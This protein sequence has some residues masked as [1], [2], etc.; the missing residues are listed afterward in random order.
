MSLWT[1]IE[2]APATAA[3]FSWRKRFGGDLASVKPWFLKEVGGRAQTVP[4]PWTCGCVHRVLPDNRATCDCGDCEDIE[5][6]EDD[7]ALW[8]PNW[9]GLGKAVAKALECRP[10]DCNEVHDGVFEIGAF[11]PAAVPVFLI[12]ARD[13]E[14]FRV[15]VSELVA[16]QRKAFGLLA[17]T[18][19]HYD[20][21]CREL[22]EGCGAVFK[23]LETNIEIT[24]QGALQ[25][26]TG[27]VAGELLKGLLAKDGEAMPEDTA[28][29]VFAII[30]KM[31]SDKVT[32]PP[33]VVAVFRMVCIEGVSTDKAGP[34]L[35]CSKGTVMNRVEAIKAAT[36]MTLAQLRRMSGHF[37]RMEE[38]LTDSRAKNIYRRGQTGLLED[39]EDGEY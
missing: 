36:G 16:R 25:A 33:S 19:R 31:E 30:Q 24:A 13:G 28:R 1:K 4:C 39:D 37:E 9:V 23:D 29:G 34:K 12:V 17:P 27:V 11:G 20:A 35:G 38:Q 15:A 2:A 8:R 14:A 21:R 26:K 22:M 32:K 10:R 7:V 3:W 6:T 5:L 18:N